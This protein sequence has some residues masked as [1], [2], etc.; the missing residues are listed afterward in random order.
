M[1]RCRTL[2]RFRPAGEARA[3]SRNR[4]GVV[5]LRTGFIPTRVAQGY[6]GEGFDV[7][8]G[9]P[10]VTDLGIRAL[11]TRA[12]LLV[13]AA[14]YFR[15]LLASMERAQTSITIVGWDI[16]SALELRPDAEPGKRKVLS[17]VLKGLTERNPALR[18]R[19][20]AWDYSPLYIPER[21]ILPQVQF[22]WKVG[23]GVDMRLASDHPVGASHH[24]KMVVV[25]DCLAFVGGIDLTVARWD[26]RAHRAREPAR[27]RA[28]GSP[29][30]PFHDAQL[31]MDGDAAR[32]LARVAEQRWCRAT[33]DSS[34][35]MV[36]AYDDAGSSD[37]WPQGVEPDFRDVPVRIVRTQ[38]AYGE[39]PALDEVEALHLSWLRRARRAIY[40]ENQYLTAGSIARCLEERLRDPDGP[41]IV[42]V[43]P[44][45]QSG[46]LEQATMGILRSRVVRRLHAADC[47]RRLRVLSPVVGPERAAIHVHAKLTAIDDRVLR[48]GSANLSN[49]SMRLDTECD[50]AIEPER[51]ED[52]ARVRGI[53][54]DLLAEHLGV[55]AARVSAE[56]ERH[57]SLVQ[58]I[59][60]LCANAG[61]RTLVDL[62][63]DGEREPTEN[64]NGRDRRDPWFAPEL[65]DPIEPLDL[66]LVQQALPAVAIRRGSRRFPRA[67]LATALAI[68]LAAL[69]TWT[70]LRHWVRPDPIAEAADA[71]RETPA[72]LLLALLAYI[73]ASLAFVPVTAL[74]VAATWVFG[75]W[76]G[77][78]VAATGNLGSAAAAY[79]IGSVLWRDLV[80]SLAGKRLRALND[81][82]AKRGMVAMAALRVVPIAPFTLVNIVAGA[83]RIRFRHY[84]AG[85]ALGMAPG[86]VMIC[87]ASDRIVRAVRDPSPASV[88]VGA[89]VAAL[90]LGFLFWL[91]KLATRLGDTSAHEP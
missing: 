90:A 29:Y 70:P 77:L 40:L 49:R 82:L 16:H 44:R 7:P 34:R 43:T 36:A 60:A 51:Q 37:P 13:D 42:V 50:V 66:A 14:A 30:G 87:L 56:V 88:A 65:A 71:L 45:E 20:L 17:R 32:Q 69:W 59:D 75:G 23:R 81:A 21:E 67:L 41:E 25:D 15:A 76:S 83:S 73:G 26:E 6:A 48:V 28:D 47:H 2:P 19:I 91:R 84:L 72:G 53:R 11:A 46:R 8:R 24:Q 74:T 55:D 18:V 86:T 52:R 68:A 54:D 27:R 39:E 31:C 64:D 1:D 22:A 12:A 78:L 33:H 57:G 80:Q 61:D 9:R 4:C 38:A 35:A 79:G 5:V 85:T 62:A 63:V 58:A 89:G 10:H 3:S